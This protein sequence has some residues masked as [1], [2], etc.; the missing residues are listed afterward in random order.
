LTQ[1]VEYGVSVAAVDQVGNVGLLSN[2]VCEV[3]VD[4]PDQSGGWVGGLCSM[5]HRRVPSP[6]WP[7]PVLG[8]LIGT[9]AVRRIRRRP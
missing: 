7:S 9:R 5:S 4:I 1:G 2:T 3:P 6:V 8:A